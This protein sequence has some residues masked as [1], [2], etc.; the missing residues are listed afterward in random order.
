MNRDLPTLAVRFLRGETCVV[1]P[2]P[3]KEL[4]GTVRQIGPRGGGA[5]Q[6]EIC[7]RLCDSDLSTSHCP[8]IRTRGATPS[9]QHPGGIVGTK[10]CSPGD[11]SRLSQPCEQRS[12]EFP[13]PLNPLASR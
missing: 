6:S 10:E 13:R 8:P 2:S 7:A 9:A 1:V 3:V 5:H 12:T 4:V 11:I